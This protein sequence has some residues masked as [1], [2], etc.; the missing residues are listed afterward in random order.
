MTARAPDD[1][2]DVER[3]GASDAIHASA[4]VLGEA[5]V[6]IRGPSGSGKSSLALALL[7]LADDR[8]LFARLIG[9]DRVTIRS[10]GQRILA[11]G[12]PNMFGLIEK[13][14]YGVVQAPAEACVLVRLVVDLLPEGVRA[15]R[16]PGEDALNVS[17][18]G[19]SLPRLAFDAASA[20]FDRAFAVL[21]YL[22][23][24]SDKNM[25][26]FAHFA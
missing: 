23:R 11:S 15:E 21:G 9:D 12:A 4:I 16:L 14:G 26:E 7:A 20:L 8:R 24:T 18:R 25:T 10:E 1:L 6:L 22:D 5:G 2:E 17:L 13:R 19:A 3:P